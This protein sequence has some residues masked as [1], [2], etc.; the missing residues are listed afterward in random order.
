MMIFFFVF[1]VL[2]IGGVGY[3]GSYVC[4]VLVWVG[5]L[6]VCFDNFL[7]GYVVVVKF[8]LLE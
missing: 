1:C 7:I 4:K 3:I 8:G 5:F 2:V 6:F